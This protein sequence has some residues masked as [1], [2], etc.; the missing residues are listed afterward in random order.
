MH[1]AS[2]SKGEKLA[3]KNRIY[4]LVVVACG[5]TLGVTRH[6]RLAE[7]P[8]SCSLVVAHEPVQLACGCSLAFT[9]KPEPRPQDHSHG[10]GF[11]VKQIRYKRETREKTHE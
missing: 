8:S 5:F 6:R 11:A 7:D 3:T 10:S 1:F 9:L 4:G 2:H